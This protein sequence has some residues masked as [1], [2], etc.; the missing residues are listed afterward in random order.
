[1]GAKKN[2]YILMWNVRRKETSRKTDTWLGR[3]DIG[4]VVITKTRRMRW[5]GHAARMSENSIRIGTIG[6]LL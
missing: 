6:G 2:A 1:M 3:M 4:K 5:A